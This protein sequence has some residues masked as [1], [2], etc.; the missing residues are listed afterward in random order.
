MDMSHTESDL[1]RFSI[2][3]LIFVILYFSITVSLMNLYRVFLQGKKLQNDPVDSIFQHRPVEEN[4]NQ[5]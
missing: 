4:K 5:N 3:D 2:C 1:M